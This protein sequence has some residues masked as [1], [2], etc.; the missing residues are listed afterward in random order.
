M[1][2]TVSLSQV[3]H[4]LVHISYLLD[5]CLH[6]PQHTGLRLL[7]SICYLSSEFY[8][9]QFIDPQSSSKRITGSLGYKMKGIY[10]QSG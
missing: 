4:G 3:V 2:K 10:T 5:V 8:A 9:L 6:L 1:N 7:W